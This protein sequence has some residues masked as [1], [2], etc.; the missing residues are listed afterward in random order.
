MKFEIKPIKPKMSHEEKVYEYARRIAYYSKEAST[1]RDLSKVFKCHNLIRNLE[2]TGKSC[3]CYSRDIHF[4]ETK[5]NGGDT[6]KCKPC[7]KAH[8]HYLAFREAKSKQ[9]AAMRQLAKEM[10]NHDKGE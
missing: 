8:V 10:T 6:E 4:S 7:T 9:G 5:F 3:G 1:Q 2:I